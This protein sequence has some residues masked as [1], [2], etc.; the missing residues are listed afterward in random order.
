M[1]QQIGDVTDLI[2]G[3]WSI[4]NVLQLLPVLCHD[5]CKLLGT[6]FVQ[7]ILGHSVQ[8]QEGVCIPSNPMT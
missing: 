1:L 7:V 8:R 2:E 4:R 3:Q 5:L 6:P